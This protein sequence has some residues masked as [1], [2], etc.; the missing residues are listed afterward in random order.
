MMYFL[1]SNMIMNFNYDS[2]NGVYIYSN[3]QYFIIAYTFTGQT[4]F[5]YINSTFV[6]TIIAQCS[7]GIGSLNS[8][9]SLYSCFVGEPITTYFGSATTISYTN[10][11]VSASLGY[12]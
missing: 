1:G 3:G 11:Y 10:P 5:G 4:L 12:T 6:N 9:L 8:P 7:I 2:T